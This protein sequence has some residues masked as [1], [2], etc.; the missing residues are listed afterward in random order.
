VEG[1]TERL[2]YLCRQAGAAEYISGPAAK[3]YIVPGLFEQ[4]SIRLTWMDYSGYPEYRQLYP[5]FE[6]AVSIID[7]LFSEG[8]EAAKY[9]KS[10]KN[11]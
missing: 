2:V 11:T 5:P 4:Y 1:K 8:P 9:M 10:F 7:L 6:H 3:N